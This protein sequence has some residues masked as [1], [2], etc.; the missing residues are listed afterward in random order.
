MRNK[1]FHIGM[2]QQVALREPR[3]RAHIPRHGD[4]SVAVLEPPNDANAV[5][6]EPSERFQEVDVDVSR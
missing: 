2:S 6:L 3:Y 4:A 1:Q 5:W